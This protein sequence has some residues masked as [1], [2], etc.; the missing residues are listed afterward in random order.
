M[1]EPRHCSFCD[2]EKETPDRLPACTRPPTRKIRTEMFGRPVIVD[3]CQHHYDQMPED[4]KPNQ[5]V[6]PI[7][8]GVALDSDAARRTM[9]EYLKS[10][11]VVELTCKGCGGIL[12]RQY[13]RENPVGIVMQ[14][15]GID[16]LV[17]KDHLDTCDFRRT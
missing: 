10:E 8:D 9:M 13:E 16:L 6:S 2:S 12:V 11:R 17:I 4:S 1:I 5:F 3:V 15:F 14:T 7:I